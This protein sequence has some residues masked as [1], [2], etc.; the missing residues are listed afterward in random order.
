M[1][2]REIRLAQAINKLANYY[3]QFTTGDL[4]RFLASSSPGTTVAPDAT[5]PTPAT[6]RLLNY[7]P[8]FDRDD[9]MLGDLIN[10]LIDVS[11]GAYFVKDMVNIC[12]DILGL[13]TEGADAETEAIREN[14]KRYMTIISDSPNS[15]TLPIAEK[16]E[17]IKKTLISLHGDAAAVADSSSES[18]EDS[19]SPR[20]GYYYFLSGDTVGSINSRPEPTKESPSVALIMSHTPMLSLNNRFT[21]AVSIFLNGMPGIEMNRSMPYLDVQMI[22]GRPAVRDDKLFAP[23]IYKFLLGAETA[24]SGTVLYDLQSANSSSSPELANIRG[25][26]T[27]MGMEGFTNPQ[28]LVPINLND[29]TKRVTEVFDKFQPFMSILDF[30]VDVQQSYGANAFRT[31]KLSLM[32]HDRSRMA[33][34]AE[35][36]RPDLIF[37]TQFL[38]DYGWIHPD[39]EINGQTNNAYADLIN[40]MRFKEKYSVTNWNFSFGENGQVKVDLDL[41]T[42]GEVSFQQELIV[43]DGINVGNTTSRINRL[44][45]RI[46]ELRRDIFDRE[47]GDTTTPGSS[48]A[49][50]TDSSETNSSNGSTRRREIR[51]I[52]FLDTVNDVFNNL[53]LNAEQNRQMRE[54]MSYLSTNSGIPNVS[55]LRNLIV[56]LYGDARN[57]TSRANST[58]LTRTVA[59]QVREQLRIKLASLNIDNQDPLLINEGLPPGAGTRGRLNR[60]ARGAGSEGEVSLGNLLLNFIALPLATTAQY[61]EIQIITYP[62]NNYAGY[63]NRINIANF[64]IDVK[65]FKDKYIDYVLSNLSRSGQMSLQQFWQFLITYIL[66]DH[67]ARSY[68]L[69]DNSGGL[70][71]DPSSR[72]RSGSGDSTSENSESES[73]DSAMQTARIACAL[74]PVTP[75]G[76]FRMPQVSYYL[77]SVPAKPAPNDENS[78]SIRE[79]TILRLHI[80]DQTSDTRGSLGQILMAERNSALSVIPA[81]PGLN[82]SNDYPSLVN[83]A[84]HYRQVIDQATATNLIEV[85]DDA[86]PERRFRFRGGS[87]EIKRFLYSVMPSIIYGTHGT[88]VKNANVTSLQDQAATSINIINA[89]GRSGEAIDPNGEDAGGLPLQVIPVEA[90]ITTMGCPLLTHGSQYY[91][92]FGTGTTLDDIYMVNG[93]SHRISRGEFTTTAKLIPITGFG[94]YRNYLNQLRDAARALNEIE[95]RREGNATADITR[96]NQALESADSDICDTD[97]SRR[98]S[99]G[100]GRH[101]GPSD[102]TGGG[103][104]SGGGATP[105]PEGSTPE[106]PASGSIPAEGTAPTTGETPSFGEDI[107]NYNFAEGSLDRMRADFEAINPEAARARLERERAA[108]REARDDAEVYRIDRENNSGLI[109]S[110]FPLPRTP[111]EEE[112]IRRHEARMR[113]EEITRTRRRTRP[114]PGSRD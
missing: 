48:A 90:S 65:Y 62:F 107:F 59:N 104:G 23:S 80:F 92:D 47:S 17:K 42:V 5:T 85:V 86:P 53:T 60:N 24:Q 101:S 45:E 3:G 68:G 30:T 50:G 2:R 56:E 46:G 35:L 108:E 97:R 84:N 27:I 93:L 12:R 43:N 81:V 114:I 113:L 96:A 41:S 20:N 21:N 69:F 82:T 4:S 22:A 106:T 13:S 111:S 89:P 67:G 7:T 44:I 6:E 1:S 28:T 49:A 57:G 36:F 55:E 83:A 103:G 87:R 102:G 54:F 19:E 34:V 58:S 109:R 76:S 95:R 94:T 100:R 40:G 51:G 71:T 70:W 52:Q 112:A 14:F 74:R 16:Y 61:D 10:M 79:K 66:D 105:T 88:L 75:D 78:D 31:A 110:W 98:A 11:D 29:S 33:E 73:Y 32:L 91:V 8:L 72:R 63:A 15:P 18:T 26:Y 37:G 99:G 77:E 39:G 25:N 38:I 64:K 9:Q